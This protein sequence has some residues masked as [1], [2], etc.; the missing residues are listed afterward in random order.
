M[1][2]HEHPIFLRVSDMACWCSQCQFNVS[3]SLNKQKKI[4][5]CRTL[6]KRALLPAA[7]LIEPTFTSSLPSASPVGLNNLGNTCFMNSS[8]QCLFSAQLHVEFTEIHGNAPILKALLSTLSLMQAKAEKSLSPSSLFSALSQKWKEYKKCYQQDSHEFI[9]RLLD[10]CRDEEKRI[11]D[12]SVIDQFF[13]GVFVSILKC[14]E[15]KH[16]SKTKDA[17]LDLSISLSPKEC[18]NVELADL[19]QCFLNEE[20]LKDEERISCEKCCKDTSKR[21]E[22][23]KRIEILEYPKILV[24]HLKRFTPTM[25]RRTLVYAKDSKIVSFDFRL[26]LEESK[27]CY[28]LFALIEHQGSD[29]EYG[30][31]I[32]YTSDSSSNW[33]H[34]SDSKVKSVSAKSVLSSQPYIL[35]YRL[36]AS[37]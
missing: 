22:A 32:S 37:A 8:L 3:S 36:A 17:F 33:Y 25:S 20:F 15:C 29:A 11:K 34:C 10:V 18:K 23:I 28:E 24:L 12:H 14:Q 13:G 6:L 16:V 26:D 4:D 35:F 9:R 21:V 2:E 5:E 19:L 1:E 27:Y 30:H 31:Y 7:E